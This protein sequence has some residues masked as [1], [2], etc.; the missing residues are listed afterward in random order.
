MTITR[1]WGRPEAWAVSLYVPGASV[2]RPTRPLKRTLLVPRWPR[3]LKRPTISQDGA[4]PRTT[5]TTRAGALSLK[6]IRVP[7]RFEPGLKRC[8]EAFS[9]ETRARLC[10]LELPA[11]LL[12]FPAE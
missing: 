6:V 9:R 10:E 12:R 8:G 3:T 2:L 1:R 7:R 4:G 11:G 5:K